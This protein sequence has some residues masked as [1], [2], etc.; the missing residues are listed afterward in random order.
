MSIESTALP[1]IWPSSHGEIRLESTA[2]LVVAQ[3]FHQHYSSVRRYAYA[4]VGRIPEAEDVAQESFV[5]LLQRLERGKDVEH[6]LAWLL[7]VAHN[8]ALDR[9]GKRPT[10]ISLEE[11]LSDELTCSAP[12]PEQATMATLERQRVWAALA[13]LS[14]QELRCWMLRSEGLR[15]R[16]IAEVLGVRTGTVATLLVRATGK[17]S[18]GA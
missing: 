18:A 13:G 5:R 9:L 3:N 8:L 1:A 14:S 4:I 15:Y 11:C 2:S 17:L 6:P 7:R 12:N 10:E 16:E